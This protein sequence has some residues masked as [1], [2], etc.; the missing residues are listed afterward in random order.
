MEIKTYQLN[1]SFTE[2]LTE[3]RVY[4]GTILHDQPSLSG[5]QLAKQ[6]NDLYHLFLHKFSRL[7]YDPYLSHT[8]EQE[9]KCLLDQLLQVKRALEAL[10]G[11]F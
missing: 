7:S 5:R 8:E 4:I 3:E 1:P 9:I 10:D 6:F 11:K 2:V